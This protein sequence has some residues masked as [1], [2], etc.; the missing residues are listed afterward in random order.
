MG[1]VT[2]PPLPECG[3][4]RCVNSS[5]VCRGGVIQS[6]EN[7]F[8]V[9]ADEAVIVCDYDVQAWLIFSSCLLAL[10]VVTFV[11]QASVIENMRQVSFIM[12]TPIP[13]VS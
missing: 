3:Y 7:L 5:C 12:N 1:C 2:L 11:I 13:R 8:R 10:T 4:G 9:A 6:R